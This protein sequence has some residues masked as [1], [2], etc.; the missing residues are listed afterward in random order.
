MSEEIQKLDR[1]YKDWQGVLVHVVGFDRPGER[2]IYMREGYEHECAYPVE[3]FR[4][5]FTRIL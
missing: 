1:R 2:V 4:K 3:R 5:R